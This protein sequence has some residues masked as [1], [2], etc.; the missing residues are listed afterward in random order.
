M[1]H[2]S[3]TTLGEHNTGMSGEPPSAR[4]V[5]QS[6]LGRAFSG[7][8]SLL[9]DGGRRAPQARTASHRALRVAAGE[10]RKRARHRTEPSGKSV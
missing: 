2:T 8:Y 5:P 3:S 4:S 10:P 6:A 9:E 1:A 7:V